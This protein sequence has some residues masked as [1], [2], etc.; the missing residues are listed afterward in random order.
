MIKYL[1]QLYLNIIRHLTLRYFVFL[2]Q[3]IKFPC[4]VSISFYFQFWT[5]V[6]CAFYTSLLNLMFSKHFYVW[7]YQPK[8]HSIVFKRLTECKYKKFSWDLATI[9]QTWRPQVSF[10]FYC[11]AKNGIP[12]PNPG[13]TT[14][15]QSPIKTCQISK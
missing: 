1:L 8:E 15:P 7:S 11:F 3:A 4:Y 10:W 14:I 9:T 12:K 13:Y 5:R 6:F 2:K